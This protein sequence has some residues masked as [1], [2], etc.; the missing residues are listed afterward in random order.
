MVD[1]RKVDGGDV[2]DGG[3][4]RSVEEGTATVEVNNGKR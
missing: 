4:R 1:G 2:N 3:R